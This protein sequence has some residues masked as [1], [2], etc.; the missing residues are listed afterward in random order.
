MKQLKKLLAVLLAAALLLPWI[1]DAAPCAAADSYV[2]TVAEDTVLTDTADNGMAVYI[3]GI[4]YTP[5]TTLQK[6][7]SVWATYS[8]ED[9]LVTVYHSGSLLYFEL[10]SGK[11][12]NSDNQ[13]VQVSARIRGGVP[14]LP[15]QIICSWLNLYIS[16]TSASDSGVGYPIVRLAGKKPALSNNTVFSRNADALADVAHSRDVRSGIAT[17]PGNPTPIPTPEPEHRDISLLFTG[18]PEDPSSLLETLG[19]YRVSAAF[20]LSPQQLLSSAEAVRQLYAEDYPCGILLSGDDLLA[21]AAEG[22]RLYAK[23]LRTRIR[24]VCCERDL[25]EEEISAL[26][27]AGFTAVVPDFHA[28]AAALN[29]KKPISALQKLLRGAGKQSVLRFTPDRAVLDV[30]PVFCSYL[31]AQNFTVTPVRRW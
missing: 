23:I 19:S 27:E 24:T 15:V 31:V 16:Y 30:L 2:I 11:T 1:G 18:L 12:Y 28:D 10:D 14:Y 21:E 4:I 20:F 7:N 9:E 6:L 3:D 26:R 25:S 29:T 8:T 5:Y 22:S 17:D 13:Y